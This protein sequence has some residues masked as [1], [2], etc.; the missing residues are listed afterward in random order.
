MKKLKSR[1]FE[2]L[3]SSQSW[4]VVE[5]ELVSRYWAPELKLLKTWYFKSQHLEGTF[6]RSAA[7]I[8][9]IQTSFIFAFP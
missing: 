2:S 9:N 1:E 5:M 7:I 8:G 4:D 3:P 6:T